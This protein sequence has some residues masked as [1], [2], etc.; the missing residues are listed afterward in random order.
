LPAL[1]RVLSGLMISS[2]AGHVLRQIA[3]TFSELTQITKDATCEQLQKLDT[4]GKTT[5]VPR[6]QCED[7]LRS[8]HAQ[9][10]QNERL[11]MLLHRLLIDLQTRAEKIIFDGCETMHETLRGIVLNFAEMQCNALRSTISQGRPD[12]GWKCQ[13]APLRNLLEERYIKIYRQAEEQF[14]ELEGY[15][16]TKLRQVLDRMRPNSQQPSECGEPVIAGDPPSLSPSN[17]IVA[18]E[19]DEPWWKKWWTRD[20][21]DDEL[22]E[23]LSRRIREEFYPVVDELIREARVRLK[24]Q[25]AALVKRSTAVYVGLVQ[26]LQEHGRA[27]LVRTRELTSIRD[28][29]NNAERVQQERE[30]QMSAAKQILATIERLSHRL[31]DFDRACA[32]KIG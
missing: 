17:N 19:F 29:A 9:L 25:Q 23:E 32:A 28:A 2:H 31:A 14:R 18:L 6:R 20:R 15:I 7:E 5:M 16:F 13:T 22:I 10:S 1:S 12:S 26:I 3:S 24:E 30:A 27:R 8:I 11:M 21:S 4:G